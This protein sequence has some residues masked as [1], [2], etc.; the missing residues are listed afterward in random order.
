MVPSTSLHQPT[1]SAVPQ[2]FDRAL[3]RL[4]RARGQR[5]GEDR[6]L[7]REAA[8]GLSDRLGAVRRRFHSALDLA[9][10]P[11]SR[12]CLTPHA[13]QWTQL[14]LAAR[15]GG[16]LIGDEEALPFGMQRFDLVTSVL[17]LHAVNDLPGTLVQIRNLLRP[18]G[19]FVAALFGGDTLHELRA[20]FAAAELE[21]RGG[22]SPRV[23][24][25]A[26]VRSLGLL[27][28]RAG[29]ALPVTDVERTTVNYNNFAILVRDLRAMGE[30][31]YLHA[32]E[33]RPLTRSVLAAMLAHYQESFG[34]SQGQLKASFD[35][36]YMTAWAPH[37]SQPKPL[38]PGAATT[39][40]AE[41]LGT[42]ERRA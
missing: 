35:I 1:N 23:S 2:I 40:L 14:T 15:D 12:R 7:L 42:V 4:R 5:F 25:F 9:S 32:R 10:S 34:T 33:R 22:L 29:F 38:R 13:E 20:A 41:A 28:Q 19:L 17:S 39:R 3:Y 6:F 24:P 31:N 16:Q 36:V 11:E 30:V 27:L 18:D 21:L 8:D 37:D 26:D